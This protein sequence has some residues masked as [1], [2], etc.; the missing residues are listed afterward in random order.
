MPRA[1]IIEQRIIDLMDEYSCSLVKILHLDIEIIDSIKVLNNEIKEL[2][3]EGGFEND[4]DTLLFEEARFCVI[5]FYISGGMDEIYKT[6]VNLKALWLSLSRLPKAFNNDKIT[7]LI[8]ISLRL[9]EKKNL[10]LSL[11]QIAGLSNVI[12][13]INLVDKP[14]SPIVMLNNLCKE[15]LISTKWTLNIVPDDI[16]IAILRA[17]VEKQFNNIANFIA[18]FLNITATSKYTLIDSDTHTLE[19]NGEIYKGQTALLIPHEHSSSKNPELKNKLEKYYHQ[20]VTWQFNDTKIHVL[21]DFKSDVEMIEF[22]SPCVEYSRKLIKHK[23]SMIGIYGAIYAQ[24][25]RKIENTTVK[26]ALE[27][28]HKAISNLGF[29]CSELTIKRVRKEHL[30]VFEKK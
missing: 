23:G 8:N 4:N 17:V 2:L 21:R 1:N 13:I 15:S 25:I 5:A 3:I 10:I 7:L 14:L 20:L 6:G 16:D 29:T 24:L 9:L 30:E 19:I 27:N 18:N 28:A 26:S 11:L 12:R 22:C